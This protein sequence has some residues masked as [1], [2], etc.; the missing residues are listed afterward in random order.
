ME[1]SCSDHLLIRGGGEGEAR[2]NIENIFSKSCCWQIN[3]VKDFKSLF[4]LG[5]VPCSAVGAPA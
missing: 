5:T 4:W 1:R 3:K 2:E